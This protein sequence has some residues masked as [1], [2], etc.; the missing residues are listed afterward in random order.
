MKRFPVKGGSLAAVNDVSFSIKK[1]EIFGLLGVNGA[2]KSTTINILSGLTL[3]DSGTIHILGKDFFQ[4]EEE[5]RGKFNLATAYYSLSQHL[6]VYQ[7]LHIYAQLYEVKNYQEKIRGLA[8]QFLMLQHLNTKVRSLSSGEKSRLNLIK[9]LLNDPQLLFL[10]ECTVGL[11]PEMAEIARNYLLKYNR[12][13]GCTILF[14][15]HY[16]Q[17]VERLCD[18]IAFMEQGKIIKIGKA[19]DL[20]KEL[21]QQTVRLHFPGQVQKAKKILAR[22]NIPATTERGG[23]LAFCIENKKKVLYPILE[24]FI[25]A[26]LPFD[27]LTL[28]K[29]TLEDYF[30]SKARR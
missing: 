5:I 23:I 18:R 17:E 26:E 25:K 7:N 9:A 6:T 16:M 10:D 22:R 12:E 21:N 3:P 28:E 19:K 1:G 20:L 11:D 13:T 30:I 4:Y 14:T 29:P 24:A 27:D 15:S 2:G 8:E